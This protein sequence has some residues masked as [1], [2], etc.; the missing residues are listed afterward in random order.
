MAFDLSY[1]QRGA[2]SEDPIFGIGPNWSCSFR[3]YLMQ[4]AT[5]QPQVFH[6]HKL[7]A[8]W[9]DYSTTQI[10]PL[11]GSVPRSVQNGYEI[12]YADGSIESFAQPFTNNAGTFFSFVT[13]RADPTGNATTFNYLPYPTPPCCYANTTVSNAG[14]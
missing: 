8:G 12:E 14:P 1:R 4:S 9:I 11:D 2:V 10:Q 13:S 3:T 6:L 7:G 5:D